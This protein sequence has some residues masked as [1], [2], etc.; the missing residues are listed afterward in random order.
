MKENKLKVYTIYTDSH[1]V[2]FREFFLPSLVNT[3][4]ELHSI[5]MVQKGSGDFMNDGWRNTM[6]TKVRA[7]I[8]TIKDDC[9]DIFIFSDVDIIFFKN[10]SDD[11]LSRMEGKDIL[12]QF[13]PNMLHNA[14][15]NCGFFVCRAND[16]TLNLWQECEKR[17]SENISSGTRLMHEQDYINQIIKENPSIIKFGILPIDKYSFYLGSFFGKNIIL[18][19]KN[20]C[21]YHAIN[22][23]IPSIENK[24]LVLSK[25][26]KIILN[27]QGLYIW[28]YYIF[29]YMKILIYWFKFY[30]KTI[31]IGFMNN[32][33]KNKH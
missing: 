30:L 29:V 14:E 9:N 20:I 22:T 13:Q 16:R 23:A 3:D 27:K 5:K 32:S 2:L 26:K 21:T 11:L 15:M 28:G 25:A 1:E 18:L 4:L 19:P 12:F 8:K 6:L 31:T 7:I 17:L 24:K 33:I 10:I